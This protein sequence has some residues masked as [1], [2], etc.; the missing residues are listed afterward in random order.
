MITILD[1]AISGCKRELRIARKKG[2]SDKV[3]FYQKELK[4][5]KSLQDNPTAF[6]VKRQLNVC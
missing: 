1:Y 2:D 3:K 4:S 6:A 5:L